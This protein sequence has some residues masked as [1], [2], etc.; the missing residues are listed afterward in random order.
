MGRSFLRQVSDNVARPG[1]VPESTT[2]PTLVRKLGIKYLLSDHVGEGCA[3]CHRRYPYVA[4]KLGD[5][6]HLYRYHR[7]G[8]SLHVGVHRLYI[9]NFSE[10]TC[11]DGESSF[12]SEPIV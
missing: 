1:L 11:H 7:A 12:V 9:H 5:V 6:L 2:L 10:L 4:R 3:F 8:R